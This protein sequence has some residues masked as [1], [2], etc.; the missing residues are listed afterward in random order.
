MGKKPPILNR[1]TASRDFRILNPQAFGDSTP[2]AAPPRPLEPSGATK[3]REK[4]KKPKIMTRTELE[5]AAILCRENPAC[6][7]I[8]ERYTLKLSND[9]RY[10]PDFAVIH[11]DK[12]VDFHE[13]KGAFLFSGARKSSTASSL[14]KPKLA[15]ENFPQHRFFVAQKDKPGNWTREEFRSAT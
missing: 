7:I 4:A 3:M 9:C 14:T 8:Y 1:D 2:P 15:A 13:V 10:T 6:K 12:S 5:Y 11:P